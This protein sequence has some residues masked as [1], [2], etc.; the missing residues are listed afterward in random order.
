V[1]KKVGKRVEIRGEKSKS[2]KGK[3]AEGAGQS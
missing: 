3:M 1:E 2:F